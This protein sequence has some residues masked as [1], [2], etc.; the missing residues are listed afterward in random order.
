MNYAPFASF[1]GWSGAVNA[2]APKE[3]QDAAYDFL[4]VHELTG[5]LRRG[6]DARQDRLQPVPDL[7]FREHRAVD[8]RRPERGRGHQLPRRHQG[9]PQEPEHGPRPADPA[10][11]AVRAGRAGHGRLAVPGQ[12]ARCRR[13]RSRPSRTAGTPSPTRSERT[14]SSLPMSP[15]LASS[16]SSLDQEPLEPVPTGSALR[17]RATR[18]ATD[19]LGAWRSDGAARWLFIWPDRPPHPR[20]LDLPARRLDRA[21]AVPAGVPPGRRRPQ[22]H[23]LR[24]LPAAAVR[25]RAVALPRRPEV[26]V[27]ARL[28][29]R[30]RHD[31]AH[32]AG[33]GPCRPE[34][35]G[36]ADRARPPAHR[37]ACSWSASV[38]LLVQALVERRRAARARSS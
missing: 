11:E 22:V 31:R 35:T 9:Q 26:A 13:R 30:D 16:D 36:S 17:A 18:R 12:G 37:R 29:G 19:T 27:A 15:V 4:V 32:R 38:W 10:D 24:Q 7:A 25:P 8:R 33:L 28:G 21:V 14:S 20:P 34:R 5:D 1:G 23:R 2:A 6:R 3:Q